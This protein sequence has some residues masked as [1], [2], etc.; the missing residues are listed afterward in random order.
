MEGR[1]TERRR[2]ILKERICPMENLLHQYLLARTFHNHLC[3]KDIESH[4][5]L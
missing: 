1:L 3:K 2:E 5:G 4:T